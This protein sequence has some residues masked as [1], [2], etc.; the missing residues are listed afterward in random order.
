ME[1]GE[2]KPKLT[3]WQELG[4]FAKWAL[5]I[6][7]S[8]WLVSIII[9]FIYIGSY[10]V[11]IRKYSDVSLYTTG[12]YLTLIT[13]D[14]GTFGSYEGSAML[15]ERY[16]PES[17]FEYSDYVKG[18][19]IYYINDIAYDIRSFVLELQFDDTDTYEDFIS[20]EMDRVQYTDKFNISRN[21][22][23]FLVATSEELTYYYYGRDIPYEFCM[24]G[25]NQ[26]TLT[27]R[28]ICFNEFENEVSENF[29]EVFKHTN[30][31]W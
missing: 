7:G 25:K 9:L 2:K 14:A 8:F 24:L 16:L 11:D 19:Y 17:N 3:I 1:N 18:F 21:N 20:Y 10:K 4:I 15:C 5:I 26:E 27:V 30:C 31:E 12:D 28:Y 29:R 22:Y 13:D 23:N 6:G